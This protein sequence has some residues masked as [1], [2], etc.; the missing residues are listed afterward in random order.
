MRTICACFRRDQIV[1]QRS[2][3]INFVEFSEGGFGGLLYG[4]SEGQG[5]II[6]K[7]FIPRRVT[8]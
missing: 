1:S 5:K 4:D 2:G 3:R 7:I 8:S 6:I